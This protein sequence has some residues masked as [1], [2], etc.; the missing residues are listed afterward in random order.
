[1]AASPPQG[2]WT[3]PSWW[4][5][6][7]GKGRWTPA[8]WGRIWRP[9]PRPTAA[10]PDGHAGRS[11]IAAGRLATE[12]GRLFNAPQRPAAPVQ[13]LAFLVVAQDV[14]HAVKADLVRSLRA[15]HRVHSGARL[16]CESSSP[17]WTRT[18]AALEE[19]A[20]LRTRMMRIVPSLASKRGAQ[21]SECEL[22]RSDLDTLHTFTA[23]SPN[24]DERCSRHLH[25]HF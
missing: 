17:R 22:L 5:V 16:A 9:R 24:K 23:R 8:A 2:R 7:T 10:L 11:E 12:L 14:A 25:W 15:L 20:K 19:A 4:P 13:Y 6:L 3:P 1:M 18:Q 21:P